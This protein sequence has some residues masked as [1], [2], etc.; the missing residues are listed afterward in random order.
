MMTV[1]QNG[2]KKLLVTC[3]LLRKEFGLNPKWPWSWYTL[4]A[5]G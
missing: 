1:I 2:W 5:R 4:I 3:Q